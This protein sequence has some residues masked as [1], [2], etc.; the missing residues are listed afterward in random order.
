MKRID[1]SVSIAAG[2]RPTTSTLLLI[3]YK[4]N[5]NYSWLKR[6]VFSPGFLWF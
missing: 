2:V 5:F 4:N 3:W 6:S 1:E